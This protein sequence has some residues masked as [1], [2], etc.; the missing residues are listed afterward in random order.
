M[1]QI[2]M[3]YAEIGDML[4][5]DPKTARAATI[6]RSLDRKKSRDGMT[7]AKLDSEL[8]ARFI[9]AIRS[10]DTAL[11]QAVNSLHAMHQ[12]MSRG[13]RSNV[14][15]ATVPNPRLTAAN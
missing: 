8:T 3:T 11:D 1:P 6:Q 9:A 10:A 5:C 7:R 4:G 2:W 12:M 13:G 14:R 15:H